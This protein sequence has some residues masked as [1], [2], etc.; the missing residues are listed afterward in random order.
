MCAN[1]C[2]RE[3]FFCFK[4]KKTVLWCEIKFS[5]SHSAAFQKWV[6]SYIHIWSIYIYIMQSMLE[7][8]IDVTHN[9]STFQISN[10]PSLQLTVEN[11]LV[12]YICFW[13]LYRIT[14][15]HPLPNQSECRK[16]YRYDGIY[17]ESTYQKYVEICVSLSS[18]SCIS[19]H[20]V[21]LFGSYWKLEWK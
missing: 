18:G 21:P 4:K 3:R 5:F 2:V 1:V 14:V 16:I 17:C 13:Y 12:M 7:D 19:A 9:N 10:C 11:P 15:Q 6:L 20:A 8:N